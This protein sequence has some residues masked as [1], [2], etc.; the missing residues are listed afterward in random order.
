M[1]DRTAMNGSIP[2][3]TNSR[4]MEQFLAGPSVHTSVGLDWGP[5]TVR[6]RI[7]PSGQHHVW[8]PG[9]PD[10]WLVV[11]TSGVP[12][13]IEVHRKSGWQSAMSG[14]GDLAITSPGHDHGSPLRHF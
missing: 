1:G 12:R 7:E 2:S 8:I 6:C 9:T 11:T 14:P 10:P 3:E 5:L 13:N 4:Q